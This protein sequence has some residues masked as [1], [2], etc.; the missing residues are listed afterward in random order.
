[1]YKRIIQ[2]L[3]EAETAE[4]ISQVCAQ[5]TMAFQAGKITAKDNEQLFSLV[6]KIDG[7]HRA[8]VKD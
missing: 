2:A 7:I 4:D 6:S 8:G 5:I 3:I 1:M